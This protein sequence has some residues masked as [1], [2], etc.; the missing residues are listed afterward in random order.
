MEHQ[1]EVDPGR[2]SAPD[3]FTSDITPDP[4]LND[5]IQPDH[6]S[7]ASD[8][9]GMKLLEDL[10]VRDETITALKAEIN[11]LKNTGERSP[12]NADTAKKQYE[13]KLR[14][15]MEKA[16]EHAKKI[17]NE[18]DEFKKQSEEKESNL[19]HLNQSLR[20]AMAQVGAKDMK[21]AEVESRAA[22]SVDISSKLQSKIEAMER[23]YTVPPEGKQTGSVSVTDQNGTEWVLIEDRWWRRTVLG[24]RL[25]SVQLRIDPEQGNKARL[26][27]K[28]MQDRLDAKQ[29]EFVEYKRKVDLVMNEK[30]AGP[31]PI[32]S[33]NSSVSLQS[34]RKMMKLEEDLTKANSTISELHK[35]ISDMQVNE[36]SLV[37]QITLAKLEINKLVDPVKSMEVRVTELEEERRSLKDECGSYKSLVHELTSEL[38]SVKLANSSPQSSE[39]LST[40]ETPRME[41]QQP[42]ISVEAVSVA[43]QTDSGP[44]PALLRATPAI[45]VSVPETPVQRVE[46][47]ISQH[48][49][50][51]IPLRHQIKALI[52]DLEKQKHDHSMTIEQLR[53]VK[54][55]LRRIEASKKLESDLTDPVKV[56]YMRNVARKFI[57]LAP[58][59]ESVE[60]EALIPVILN[61]FG[62]EGDEA[63]SLMK[64]RQKR[65]T[66]NT[67][68][69]NSYFP[70][71]W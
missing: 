7:S 69:S 10:R 51:A 28:R 55:E 60:F 59:S 70:K 56:E 18:R 71:I 4:P 37:A 42:S 11:L 40:P 47:P 13:T 29:A 32:T 63:I 44:S 25:V 54:E 38:E 12:E 1:P 23:T 6:P 67:S 58:V 15:V 61:F 14:E 34:A 35:R 65:L 16:R 19:A 50:V 9:L 3:R 39:P 62:L 21:L 45:P 8:G 2:D 22:Q 26:E 64:E 17:A 36:K 24:D 57:A 66:G 31:S 53:V 5:P 30:L 41:P 27:L 20:D 33:E 49:A 43:T 68:S 48:D 52:T 46:N